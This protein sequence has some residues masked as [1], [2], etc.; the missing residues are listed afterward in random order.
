MAVVRH[1]AINLVRKVADKLSLKRRRK[2]GAM[3][4]QYL[5]QILGPA[6]VNA[7]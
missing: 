6:P 7:H 5:T 2:R 3:D 4:P 1:F